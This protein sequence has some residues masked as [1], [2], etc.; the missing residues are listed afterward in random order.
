[1]V[2]YYEKTKCTNPRCK[3]GAMI[4]CEWHSCPKCNGRRYIYIPAY[5][6][7]GPFERL[8]VDMMPPTNKELEGLGQ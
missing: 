1:M 7:T 6:A 8:F 2:E 3:Q 4:H 5:P